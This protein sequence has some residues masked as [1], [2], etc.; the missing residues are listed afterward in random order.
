MYRD[1]IDYE[2]D[3]LIGI[4]EDKNIAKNDIQ[5]KLNKLKYI[6]DIY[7]DDTYIS[8]TIT[9]KNNKFLKEKKLFEIVEKNLELNLIKL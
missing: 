4:Y 5:N 2:L 1:E 7:E 3:N 6:F 9:H 8:Y